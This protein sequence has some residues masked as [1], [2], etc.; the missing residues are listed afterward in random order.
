MNMQYCSDSRT[1]SYLYNFNNILERMISG[2]T[3]ASLSDSISHNFIVQMIP[4]HQ[5]AIEMSENILDYTDNPSIQTIAD[6]IIAEQTAG[7]KN[8]RDIL[9]RCS[10]AKNTETEL[11]AYRH[12]MDLIMRQ[13]FSQMKSARATSRL[14]CD[15]IRE[16]LPHHEGAVK[17][18]KI[19]LTFA[20]CRELSPILEAIINSQER[21]IVQM[22]NLA[23][24]ICC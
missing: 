1:G 15:F 11:C 8:M 5:A 4:H 7:I 23:A 18:S 13:M 14:N 21:G 3:E 20:I 10:L 6:N 16:M 19:T 24:C 9:S 12:R 17:M 22:K 2:M